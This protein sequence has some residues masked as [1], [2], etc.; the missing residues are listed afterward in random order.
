M[1]HLNALLRK[2][3]PVSKI[4]G[5]HIGIIPPFSILTCV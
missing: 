2:L 1:R 5:R 3:L 4:E